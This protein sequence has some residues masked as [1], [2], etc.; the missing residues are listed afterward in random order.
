M[1]KGYWVVSADVSDPEGFRPYVTEHA[2][3]F[4]KYGARY[5][6]RSGGKSEVVEG[7]ARSR[8]IVIEFPDY[9]S[10]I[11]CYRSPEYAKA[12]DLRKGKASMDIVILEGYDGPQPK[13]L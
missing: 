8:T 12:M 6:I 4:S 10:A 7:G 2:K 9:A 13:D 5:L 11:E 3:V 1:A